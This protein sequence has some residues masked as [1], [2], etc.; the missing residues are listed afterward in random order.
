MLPALIFTLLTFGLCYGF[1][2]TYETPA[3]T[4]RMWPTLPPAAA[5]VAAIIGINVGVFALWRAWPPAWRLLNRYFI[6]VPAYPRVF[7]LVGNVFSHQ[8]ITHL[9]INMFVLWIFGTRREYMPYL[10]SSPCLA[11]LTMLT[12]YSSARRHW[13]RQFPCPLPCIWCTRIIRI[14]DNSCPEKLTFHHF[15]WC[16]WGDCRRGCCIWPNPFRVNFASNRT[17]D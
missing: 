16:Q 2:V 4:D 14:A 3:R 1:A 6:S 13:P 15:S 7:S 12:S 9:S 8:T 5:T 11:S 10:L 17:S